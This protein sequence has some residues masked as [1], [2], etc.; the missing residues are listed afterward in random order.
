MD[1]QTFVGNQ[2]CNY[3]GYFADGSMFSYVKNRVIALPF[4][5]KLLEDAYTKGGI[6]S[7][8][9]A[10]RDILETMADDLDVQAEELARKKLENL[11]TVVDEKKI[12]SIDTRSNQVVIGGQAV[13]EGRLA[14]LRSEAQL[15]M[16]SDLWQLIYESPKALA[17]RAMFRDDGKLDTQLL[18]GRAVLYTLSTQKKIVDIFKNINL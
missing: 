3:K 14:N 1:A 10:H 18:K 7:F 4:I 17:E 11:L 9:L 8:P 15:F 2:K 5:Q 6:D 16:E 13:D 12:V